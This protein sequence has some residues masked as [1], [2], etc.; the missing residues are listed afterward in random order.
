M[1]NQYLGQCEETA[2]GT[3]PGVPVWRFLPLI[4]GMNPKF[5]PK[6][7]ARK[8]FR[9]VDVA[10]GDATVRRKESQFTVAPEAYLYAGVE[11]GMN[12]KHLLG[13]AGVRS[14]LDVSAYKGILYP[15]TMPYGSGQNLADKAIGYS[16]NLDRDGATKSQYH[17]GVRYKSGTLTIPM[18]DD[19]SIA[20]EGQGAGDWIGAV[21]QAEIGGASFPSDTLIYHGS[22][23]RFYIGA[24]A[25]RTGTAPDF[26][27]I[28][29][30]TMSQFLP[31]DFSLK[32]T[33]GLDDKL[34]G[35]G[36]KGPSKS[37]RTGQ[38]DWEANF[39][40]DFTDPAAGFSS[41]DEFEAM[42]SA[43]KTNSLMVVITNTILAGATTAYYQEVIDLPLGHITS[44]NPDPDNEGK[45]RKV[46]FNVKRLMPTGGLKPLHWMRTDRA[47]AY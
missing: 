12:L 3:L 15:L 20:F 8:E 22:M 16:P 24:G 17:G 29:P 21:N 34:V 23:A 6:D 47:T 38:F 30:G 40:V 41:I 1:S 10:M 2:R 27:D 4:K 13:F 46:K 44:D 32:I 28:T 39:T 14:V 9:G 5:S 7:E 25:S 37:Y 19:I 31:D 11:I 42:Y 33:N 26:T 36:I 43:P 45:Q 35:N 18:G